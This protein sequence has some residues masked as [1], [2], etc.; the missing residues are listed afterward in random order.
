MRRL[1]TAPAIVLAAIVIGF[2][3][4]WSV[5]EVTEPPGPS[6][7]PDA[8]SYLGA[9]LSLAHGHGLRVPS[10]G[11]A[12]DDT[13]AALVHF[14]PGFP[15]TIALGIAAGATPANAARLVEAAAAAVTAVSLVFAAYAAGGAVAALAVLGIAAATPAFVMV[16]AGVLSEP[17]FLALLALFTWRL[18]S[19][20]DGNDTRRTIALGTIAAAAALVRYAGA[21]L[22][23]A[24]AV[25][26]WWTVSGPL[27]ATWRQRV[28][29]A[30]I[31]VEAP[32]VLVGIWMLTR[33]RNED[34]EKI[35]E[36]G[37]YTAGLGENLRGG[38]ATAA[39]WL[40]P[41]VNSD[42]ART[43]AAIAVFAALCALVARSVRA[44]R[45]GTVAEPELR[46]NRA[47]TVVA[48]S[49]VLVVGASRLVA[50]PGIPLDDRILSPLLLVVALRIGVA[51]AAFWRGSF[52]TRRGLVLLTIG[53]SASW[54]WGSAEVGAGL[55]SDFRSDGG[56]LA[57][58][59]WTA[60]PLVV[61]AAH[62]PPST[63]LYSN[64]P[65]AIW[66]STSRASFELPSDLDPG[67]VQ[68]F[69][70]KIEREH[71]ALLAFNARAEDYASPD[72]LAALAG[73]VVAE[74]WPDGTVWRSPADAPAVH[75]APDAP[76]APGPPGAPGPGTAGARPPT[77]AR[78]H[79]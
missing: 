76:R 34:A 78:L 57:A 9:G 29:R 15:A 53:I 28:R 42:A 38:L 49:Y 58:H 21:S 27:R 61:W 39:R 65:A 47:S 25:D 1:R 31:S 77:A 40:A 26:A 3:A 51:L 12:S 70:E 45:S 48:L 71:G 64:W 52:G 36:V 2:A 19:A 46:L 22:V 37:V 13:T 16:H 55:V 18:A 7:D 32:V 73:L 74:R 56:D 4:F 6:L 62:A 44:T 60:S 67:T 23:L 17:L 79:P 68:E 69:R 35:R 54:I 66:F 50:D 8:L 33:P 59:Q 30:A 63:R 43:L 75:V 11:W 5:I 24:L 10:A 41:G 20:S 72:S 14:P